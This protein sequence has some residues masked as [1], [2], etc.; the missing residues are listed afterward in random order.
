ME[1][2]TLLKQQVA[3]ARREFNGVMQD[4]SQEMGNWQPPGLANSIVDLYL[5]AVLSQDRA[6]SQAGGKPALFDTWA[7]KLNI[8]PEF[9]HTPEASRALKADV[10]TL[11]QYGDAVFGS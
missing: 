4:V 8:S 1:A 6:V 2:L 10:A 11:K 9:R 3:L 7:A 5:H